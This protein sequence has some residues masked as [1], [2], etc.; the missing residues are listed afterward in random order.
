MIIQAGDDLYLLSQKK[1]ISNLLN[2]MYL[3]DASPLPTPM[4]DNFLS[5]IDSG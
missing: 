4:A 5:K 3:P 1:H 2:K